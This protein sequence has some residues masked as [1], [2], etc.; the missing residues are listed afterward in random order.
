MFANHAVANSPPITSGVRRAISPHKCLV[1]P[2]RGYLF[3]ALEQLVRGGGR[4]CIAALS[5]HPL[6]S[7][8]APSCLLAA[9]RFW[10][11]L[12]S[13]RVNTVTTNAL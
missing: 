5:W 11:M 6:S 2:P 12:A 9:G 8:W 1:P 7:F 4:L 10:S 3:G 13:A